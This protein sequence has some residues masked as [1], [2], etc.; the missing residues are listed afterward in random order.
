MPCLIQWAAESNA[1]LQVASLTDPTLGDHRSVTEIGELILN[2]TLL[3]MPPA[4]H[5]H[6][7]RRNNEGGSSRRHQLVHDY[8]KESD[9]KRQE[10]LLDELEALETYD[11]M[12]FLF[13]SF[14]MV[15]VVDAIDFPVH[16]VQVFN[17]LR[18]GSVATAELKHSTGDESSARLVLIGN[19]WKI[20]QMDINWQSIGIPDDVTAESIRV[21][22]IRHQLRNLNE[23]L[24]EMERKSGAE[25]PDI[26]SLKTEI[27]NVRSQ[28]QQEPDTTSNSSDGVKTETAPTS[29]DGQDLSA[30]P[31]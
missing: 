7:E 26:L 13:E 20:D 8:G 10:E 4:Y 19:E 11:R 6:P 30:E 25:H 29:L 24:R 1:R 21:A 17:I 18:S 9:T 5:D 2:K 22:G 31:D 14:S 3:A 28:L 16:D 12:L 23:Q 15:S 27:D